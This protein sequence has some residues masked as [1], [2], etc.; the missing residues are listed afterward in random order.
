MKAVIVGCG[1]VGA[2]L[3]TILDAA[4]NEVSVVDVSTVAFD[5][6]PSGFRGQAIRGNGT[7][8][9]VLRR[10]GTAGADIFLAMT[11][12]DNRNVMSAQLATEVFEVRTVI[13]KINDPVRAEAYAELG[14]ATL[15]RTTLMSD[16]VLGVVGL[17]TSGAPAVRAPKGHH[18]GGEEHPLAAQDNGSANASSASSA[19]TSIARTVVA[20]AAGQPSPNARSA[21][22]GSAT[23]GRWEP[24]RASHSTPS[25]GSAVSANSAAASRSGPTSGTRSGQ[26][27]NARSGG[28]DPESAVDGSG[29]RRR[30]RIGG[31]RQLTGEG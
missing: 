31:F 25:A 28:D 12:G 23:P 15:C 4:G 17:P 24:L 13:A 1:R 20:A 18:P 29:V 8:E 27:P 11:E 7:D 14:I 16:A 3:A 19:P 30:W 5:R 26:A 21:I 6:L 2:L 22:M 9:A 10:A